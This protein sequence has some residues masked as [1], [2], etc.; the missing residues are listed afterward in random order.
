MDPEN[1]QSNDVNRLETLMRAAQDGDSASYR[2]LLTGII[3]LL[4]H[5]VRKHRTFLQPADVEDL[6]QNILLSLHAVR[7]T[8]DPARPFLP[9]L[10]AIARNRMMD[11]SRSPCCIS[12][13]FTSLWIA[14]VGQLGQCEHRQVACARDLLLA[15]FKTL[16]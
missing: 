14:R 15:Q 10:Y 9:W 4:R 2:Q 13:R 5:F 16:R 7:A 8:Y 3:P 12:E 1:G 11:G 6:V